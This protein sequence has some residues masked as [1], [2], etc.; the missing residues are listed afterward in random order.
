[1]CHAVSTGR[2]RSSSP[3]RRSVGQAS[4]R[5]TSSTKSFSENRADGI[6]HALA[7]QRVAHQSRSERARGTGSQDG[8]G[9]HDLLIEPV[10]QTAP[11]LQ[12]VGADPVEL[13][14]EPARIDQRHAAR[15]TR[16]PRGKTQDAR[17]AD[18]VP[19]EIHRIEFEGLEEL[20][21][22]REMV[23]GREPLLRGLAQAAEVHDV[24][25][26]HAAV[27]AHERGERQERHARRA[28]PVKEEGRTA[29]PRGLRV[30]VVH[31]PERGVLVTGMQAAQTHQRA[32][33]VLGRARGARENGQRRSPRRFADGVVHSLRHGWPRR[34]PRQGACEGD[35]PLPRA[36]MR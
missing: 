19:E 22:R 30:V 6:A 27:S 2:K 36:H 23:V 12:Q 26:N 11:D 18:A 4:W 31:P 3:Q 34:R 24:R 10:R 5:T 25:N 7:S 9:S 15:A 8:Q 33:G 14:A 32:E 1:M 28:E 17:A 16:E 35:M 13:E 21:Q 29:V 20:V